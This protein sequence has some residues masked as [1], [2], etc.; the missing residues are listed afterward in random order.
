[1]FKQ[2][3]M[4]F[5][6]CVLI[7]FTAISHA[8]SKLQLSLDAP[9]TI[10]AGEN[11]AIKARVT[12]PDEQAV[13]LSFKD[14]TVTIPANLIYIEAESLGD[15][16]FEVD[17]S[18]ASGNKALHIKGDYQVAFKA[19]FPQDGKAYSIWL[20]ARNASFCLKGSDHDNGSKSREIQWS[21][22]KKTNYLWRGF[23]AVTAEQLGKVFMIMKSPKSQGFV[24][25]VL[26]TSD[27]NYK[28]GRDLTSPPDVFTW[29]TLPTS[30]GQHTLT[31]TATCKGQTVTATHTVNITAAPITEKPTVNPSENLKITSS[32]AVDLSTLITTWDKQTTPYVLNSPA[33]D[34]IYDAPLFGMQMTKPNGF[35]ALQCKQFMDLPNTVSIPVN[36]KANGLAFIHTQYMQ[37]DPFHA[38]AAYNVIYD[39]NTTEQILLREEVNLAGSLRPAHASEARLLKTIGHNGVDYH[40]FLFPWVNPHPGKT[41]KQVDFTN[42]VNRANKEE[43]TTLGFNMADA[44]SQILLSLSTISDAKQA[45]ALRD[46]IANHGEQLSNTASATVDYAKPKGNISRGLFSTNETGTLS[47]RDERFDTYKGLLDEMG[48]NNIRLHSNFRLQKIFPTPDTEG[49]F[50][51]LDERITA[52]KA[53]MPDR[54]IMMCINRVPDYINPSVAQDREIFARLVSKLLAH[55]NAKPQTFVKYWEIYNEPFSKDIPEDRG[56]WKM[57]NLTAQAMR[58]VDP[59]V[60]IGG[61]APCWP[62]LNAMKDFYQHCHEQVDFISWHKYPTGNTQTPTDHIMKGTDRFGLDVQNVRKII[63]DI[64]PGKKV[65]LALTEYHINFNWRPHDPRQATNVGS[66]WMASVIYHLLINDMDIAQSWHSRSGGTFGMMSKFLEVR[67]TGQLLFI[68]NHHLKGQYVKTLSDNP[69]VEVVGFVPGK[70]KTGLLVINKSD[71]PQTLTAELL[72]TDLPVSN[73]FNANS[74]CYRIGPKGYSIEDHWLSKTPKIEMLPYEVQLIVTE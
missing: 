16:K 41:I 17:D 73:A 30:V 72:N 15:A 39:D 42:H 26:I 52:L 64:T 2:F 4:L 22:S 19:P 55:L 51:L 74:K 40:L 5:C 3:H 44:T 47:G 11:L 32:K 46:A 24:D 68:F 18:D 53:G 38:V 27:T 25:A 31:V 59:T 45:L 35:I 36:A 69:W 37:R 9:A 65:E 8:Q 50:T 7:A 63:N 12:S 70:N 20:R 29:Q 13:T 49:D 43:N 1:M 57:Y 66:T 6:M 56:H 62:I 28:P 71:I 60:K 10:Q 34:A 58:K 48:C 21:W 67:P 14:Q 61:Y 33:L 54:D 23:K